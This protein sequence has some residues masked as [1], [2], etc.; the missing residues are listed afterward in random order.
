MQQII[1]DETLKT[2]GERLQHAREIRGLSRRDLA[3]MLEITGRKIEHYEYGST[4]PPPSVCRALAGALE[5]D[6]GI[7]AFGRVPF[8]AT[9]NVNSDD[10]SA[11]DILPIKRQAIENVDNLL[12]TIDAVRSRGYV[13]NERMTIAL[14]KKLHSAFDFLEAEDIHQVAYRR[15][16]AILGAGEAHLPK[17]DS[18]D[19]GNVFSLFEA[20]HEEPRVRAPLEELIERIIDTALI[21]GDIFAAELLNLRAFARKHDVGTGLLA[22]V[23]RSHKAI[24]PLIRPVLR[25]KALERG[26][27][28]NLEG[29]LREEDLETTS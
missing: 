1:F 27:N 23:P 3:N 5:I 18:D 11:S 25:K 9:P 19:T 4:E 7:L 15:G 6:P 21:G 26:S 13:N 2:L 12:E 8:A 10:G 17:Q 20:E 14:V 29:L 28:F 16:L 22:A 24:A